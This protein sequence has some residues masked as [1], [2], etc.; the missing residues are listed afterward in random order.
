MNEYK[1]NNYELI[2]VIVPIYKVEKYLRRCIESILNQTY[3]N[4]EIILVNDGSPDNCRDICIEYSRLYDNIHYYEKS[5]G[6]LSDARNYGIERATGKYIGFI[7]SDDYICDNFYSVLYSDMINNNADISCVSYIEKFD[8]DFDNYKSDNNATDSVEVF[9]RYSAI[10]LLFSFD[11]FQNFAWNKLYRSELFENIRYPVGKNMEDLGTTYKLFLKSNR[12][13]F[14]K[15]K[16]YY[17]IQRD[18]SILHNR[19]RKYYIDKLALT[20]NRY[21]ELKKIYPEMMINRMFFLN[22][23]IDCLPY[24]SVNDPLY[25]VSYQLLCHEKDGYHLLTIKK[26]IKWNLLIHNKYLFMKLFGK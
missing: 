1:F 18:G 21:V 9:D 16:L 17:Y 11:K 13:T 7:D 19:N 12:I 24:L 10:E 20:V 5:N 15:N 3:K 14:N 6:G 4:L 26:K 25:D 23:C 22:T 2:S 8:D